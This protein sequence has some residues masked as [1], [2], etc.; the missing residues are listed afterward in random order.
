MYILKKTDEI[1]LKIFSNKVIVSCL[2]IITLAITAVYLCMA[3]VLNPW[4]V[5]LPALDSAVWLR[6]GVGMLQGDIMY[7][8]MWD[9]KGPVLFLIHYLGL[10]MTPHSITGV[11]IMECISLF[12]ALLG[13]YFVTSLVTEN[14]LVRVVS[15]LGS[16]H[17]YYYYFAEGDIVEEWA[18]PFIA[19]SLFFFGRYLKTSELK[20]IHIFLT[21]VFCAISFLLNGNL[22]SVWGAFVP[23]I[24]IKLIVEKNWKHLRKCFIYFLSGLL[25][26]V[27]IT[28]G[29]LVIH[30]ALEEFLQAYF[31]FNNSYIEGNTLSNLYSAVITSAYKE[32]WFG[33]VHVGSLIILLHQR[34]MDWKYSTFLYSCVSLVLLNMSGRQYEHYSMQLVPCM[35][36]PAAVM[37]DAL[38]RLCK[39]NKEFI[40]IL[41]LLFIVWVRFDINDYTDKIKNTMNS[42]DR[43][44]YAGGKVENYLIVNEWINYRWTDEQIEE[45]VINDAQK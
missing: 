27:F 9:H 38:F 28:A 11:W 17:G 37:A 25:L 40:F 35:V 26:V 22:V 2:I 6:C 15:V 19:F 16:M 20:E 12:A 30:G 7:V 43:N 14:R 3:S 32:P 31:G 8:D 34:K 4:S 33:Y 29:V 41:A 23:I 21:G 10:A 39:D 5:K 24:F 13:F 18:L 36:I 45:W 1:C 42:A 44:D